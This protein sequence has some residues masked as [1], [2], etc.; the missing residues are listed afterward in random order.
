MDFYAIL[1]VAS[2]ASASEIRAAYRRRAL[3]THPDKGGRVEEFRGVLEAFEVLSSTRARDKYDKVCADRLHREQRPRRRR[4]RPQEQQVSATKDQEG[5]DKQQ[6]SATRDSAAGLGHRQPKSPDV[7][8]QEGQAKPGHPRGASVRV[9][10]LLLVALTKLRGVAKQMTRPQREAA[11]H[12]L[13]PQVKTELLKFMEAYGKDGRPCAPE[14]KGNRQGARS[15]SGREFEEQHSGSAEHGTDSPSRDQE[16]GERIMVAAGLSADGIPDSE[17]DSENSDLALSEPSTST[18][19]EAGCPLVL[20]IAD[21][22]E[23][24]APFAIHD[25][26][27]NS[28]SSEE[29]AASGNAAAK[30]CTRSGS[31]GV[32]SRVEPSTGRIT[33]QANVFIDLV[34]VKA[35][36]TA[37]VE[38]AIDQHIALV[39]MREAVEAEMGSGSATFEEACR[40][41][42][43][44]RKQEFQMLALC[45]HAEVRAFGLKIHAP[46]TT[47]LDEALQV[48]ARLLSARDQGLSAVREAWLEILLEGRKNRRKKS[49]HRSQEEAE[50]FVD[51]AISKC[52]VVRRRREEH[53][54]RCQA[55]R[56]TQQE[57]R[58]QRRAAREK[59]RT[60]KAHTAE[61]RLEKRWQGNVLRVESLLRKKQKAAEREAAAEAA[62]KRRL[63]K[64]QQA[65]AREDARAQHEAEQRRRQAFSWNELKHKTFEEERRIR[66]TFAGSAGPSSGA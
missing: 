32:S 23:D 22:E 10:Q 46:A 57:Q 14:D 48:R 21:R 31:R 65:Q 63:I 13:R 7:S 53:R 19:S 27:S 15:E 26:G 33:Y 4:A 20:A 39:S 52:E 54:Q 44:A 8:P 25:A 41:A 34:A 61:Q 18:S 49:K 59:Q 36:Y 62:R 37:T 5:R 40:A 45:F 29:Q 56:E 3:Q 28:E 2:S 17:H 6:A 43:D 64:Q 55:A 11:L 50:A 30:R 9:S 66:A 38:Q 60:E 16:G 24:C 1:G 12:R 51:Q 47:S 35:A 42:Y 58:Q